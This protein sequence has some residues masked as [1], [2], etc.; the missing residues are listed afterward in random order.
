MYFII[1]ICSS[2]VPADTLEVEGWG[3]E[4]VARSGGEG[5]GGEPSTQVV[6]VVAGGYE[7]GH[8]LHLSCTARGGVFTSR[9]GYLVRLFCNEVYCLF[10]LFIVYCCH[11]FRNK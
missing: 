4:A 11:Q 10:F 5:G 2:L 7:E 3:G 1:N 8:K 9:T 6:G